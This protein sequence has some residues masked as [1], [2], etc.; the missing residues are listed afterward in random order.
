MEVCD[1]SDRFSAHQADISK[2]EHHNLVRSHCKELAFWLNDNLP[3]G[4]EKA[5]AMTY[6]EEVMMWANAGLARH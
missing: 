3:E 5:L 4:R 2:A 1:I 6:L